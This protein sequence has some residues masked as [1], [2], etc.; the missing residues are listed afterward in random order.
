MSLTRP[1][2]EQRAADGLPLDG[3]EPIAVGPAE[4]ISTADAEPFAGRPQ[5]PPDEQPQRVGRRDNAAPHIVWPLILIALGV[6]FLIGNYIANLGSLLFLALG[7][8]F[9]IARVAQREYGF[10]VPA[11]ILLGFGTFVA[12]SE[13]GWPL[14]TTGTNAQGGW[15][16]ICLAGG[17]VLVYLLGARPTLVWPL[18]PATALGIFGMLLTGSAN[19]APFARLAWLAELWPLALIGIGLWLLARPRLA[20]PLRR[21]VRTIALV[22]LVVYGLATLV[23]LVA[24][25]VAGLNTLRPG[26]GFRPPISEAREL[27]A[28]LGVGGTFRVENTSGDTTIRAGAPGAVLVTAT[29]YRWVSD[30]TIDVRLIPE[31]NTVALTATPADGS[32]FGNTPYVDYV[33]TVPADARVEASSTSGTI[34]ISDV[35][36]A[37]T[38]SASS[39]TVTLERISGAVT[40]RSSSGTLRLTDIAGDLR[41]TTSSGAITA[42]GIAQP[43]ELVASSGNI[44]VEGRFATDA[45]I[46]VSSGNATIRFAPDSAVRIAATTSSGRIGVSDLELTDRSESARALTGTLGAGTAT[47]TVQSSSGNVTLLSR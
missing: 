7:A 36:G 34:A 30:Q 44:T 16:F 31:G 33:V 3:H 1:P 12:L 35:G 14:D 47:L 25:S 17:F 27:S 46:T 26:L 15:F 4:A 37:V 43:R 21:L 18:F 39:G 13:R 42:T 19:L 11:G 41:A 40:A 2:T 38:A 10:A 45:R 8:A 28:P 6:V 24:T 20:P 9:L 22:L 29:T 32:V 23:G 5:P